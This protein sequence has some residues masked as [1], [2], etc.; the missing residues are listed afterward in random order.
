VIFLLLELHRAV[1]RRRTLL[2]NII[3]PLAL[4]A[5]LPAGNAPPAHAAVVCGVLFAFFGTF[6]SAIPLVRDAET[7]RLGSLLFAGASPRD[8]ML[9]RIAG[10]Q[11]WTC[12]SSRRPRLCW[13]LLTAGTRFLSCW[14][15]WRPRCSLPMCSALG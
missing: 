9:Q 2:L 1:R 4:I 10:I 7:G 3:V 6:G 8:L 11:C 14:P 12:C 5:A 15:A 13:R